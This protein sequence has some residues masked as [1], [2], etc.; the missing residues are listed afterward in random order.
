M[1]PCW[2]INPVE[3]WFTAWRPQGLSCAFL[4]KSNPFGKPGQ[5]NSPRLSHLPVTE[6][7]FWRAFNPS[8]AQY[9]FSF[10]SF[11]IFFFFFLFLSPCCEWGPGLN[12]GNTTMEPNLRSGEGS[13][14]F[15][16]GTSGKEPACQCKR[17][18]RCGFNPWVGKISWRYKW[19]P[20]PV[21]L[22][23]KSM[24]RGAWWATVYGVAKSWTEVT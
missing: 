6:A 3:A 14:G 12:V 24:D 19:Q 7:Y 16:G 11:F 23:G 8:F 22:P 15:P 13:R 4:V 17:H 20:I 5:P 2:I 10:L 9:I 21:V 18:K 1:R